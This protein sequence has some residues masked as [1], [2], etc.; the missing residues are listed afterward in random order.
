MG[1]A[2]SKGSIGNTKNCFVVPESNV[3]QV[4]MTSLDVQPKSGLEAQP[5]V[6]DTTGGQNTITCG[7]DSNEL[8]SAISAYIEGPKITVTWFHSLTDESY[9]HTAQ[10]DWSPTQNNVHYAFKKIN[11]FMFALKGDFDFNYEQATAKSQLTGE[12]VLYPYFCPNTSDMFVYQIEDGIYGLYKLSEAPVR[13]SIKTNTCHSIKFSLLRYLS[14]EEYNKLL[15]CVEEE[16]YFDLNNYLN[17]EGGFITSNELKVNNDATRVMN[18]LINYYN[19]EFYDAEVYRSFIDNHCLY[20]PYLIE[21]WTKLVP[22]SR[23]YYFPEQLVPNPKLWKRSFWYRLLHPDI[24]PNDLVIY[25][26][27]RVLKR[28]TYR[29]VNV[30]ALSNHCFVALSKDGKHPYPPFRIPEVFD[31]TKQTLQME[32]RLYLD[33]GKVRP[34]VIMSVANNIYK[35][36]RPAQFY[37][38]P[39]LIFLLKRM[40]DALNN[41]EDIIL[42][43]LDDTTTCI[44]D[45]ANCILDC[46]TCGH[47]PSCPPVDPRPQKD[48]NGKCFCNASCKYLINQD[49][50]FDSSEEFTLPDIHDGC[51]EYVKPEL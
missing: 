30:N 21:F 9:K 7:I 47:K 46:N 45:C 36:S 23:S 14:A 20:D 25:K 50:S 24:L 3:D 5:Y 4:E 26:A 10:T 19:T 22:V 35:C 16:V 12:G 44:N 49:G 37:F 17:T 27:F 8:T 40:I 13:L 15:E 33:Q 18:T 28:I 42:G 6:T 29:T 48:Y 38:I 2:K 43:T 39:I 11:N 34:P 32:L 41:G 51:E 31:E 1:L